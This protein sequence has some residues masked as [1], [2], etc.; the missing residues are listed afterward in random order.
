MRIGQR[1][2][3]STKQGFT[4][5]QKYNSFAFH[6]PALCYIALCFVNSDGLC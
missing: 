1:Q 4:V 3:V 2:S 6:Y 5:L